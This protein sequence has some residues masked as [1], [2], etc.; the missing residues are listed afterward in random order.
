MPRKLYHG[1]YYIKRWKSFKLNIYNKTYA[2]KHVYIYIYI[3]DYDDGNKQVY[4]EICKSAGAEIYIEIPSNR[5]L[6]YS[7]SVSVWKK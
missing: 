6:S 5:G 1:I 2:F 4:T 3:Y 7:N